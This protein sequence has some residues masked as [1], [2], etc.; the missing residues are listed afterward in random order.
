MWQQTNGTC[1]WRTEGAE[2]HGDID[3]LFV[4]YT[5]ALVAQ[6][7]IVWL[8]KLALHKSLRVQFS[9]MQFFLFYI[10]KGITL[11]NAINPCGLHMESCWVISYS[12]CSDVDS[13]LSRC[14]SWSPGGLLLD[15]RWILDKNLAGLRPK[16]KCLKST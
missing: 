14:S 8:L 13:M 3:Y 2:R 6:W 4:L 9:I 16:K 15:S 5:K 10:I 12:L 11:L 7:L 1:V